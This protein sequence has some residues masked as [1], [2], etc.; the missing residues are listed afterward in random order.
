MRL[1]RSSSLYVFFMFLPIHL[2]PRVRDVEN[3]DPSIPHCKALTDMRGPLD[4]V[5]HRHGIILDR[6]TALAVRIGQHLILPKPEP[7]RSLPWRQVSGGGEKG[8]L[9]AWF[10]T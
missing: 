10:F 1:Q 6:D 9:Q 8:P 4:F 7:S 3:P 5:D 2:G